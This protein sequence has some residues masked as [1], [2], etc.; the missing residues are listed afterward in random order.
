MPLYGHEGALVC[1]AFGSQ[2]VGLLYDILADAGSPTEYRYDAGDI[3]LFNEPEEFT[4]LTSTCTKP[5][6]QKR[7][8]QLRALRPAG[9]GVDLALSSA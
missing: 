1:A 4:K 5:A 3:A 2:K 9:N 8:E 6:A 7:F